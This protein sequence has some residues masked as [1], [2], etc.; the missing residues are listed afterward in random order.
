MNELKITH[1]PHQLNHLHDD[2]SNCK[3]SGYDDETA[4][5]VHC[6]ANSQSVHLEMDV[7]DR[8]KT[9]IGM[10]IHRLVHHLGDDEDMAMEGWWSLG[11]VAKQF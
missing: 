11:A 4:K 5:D 6:N 10:M 8:Y 7:Q 2:V 3:D 1:R 9:S